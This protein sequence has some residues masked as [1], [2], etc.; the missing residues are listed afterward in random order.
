M[1]Y[2]VCWVQKPTDVVYCVEGRVCRTIA[3]P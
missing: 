1:S 3:C 2:N